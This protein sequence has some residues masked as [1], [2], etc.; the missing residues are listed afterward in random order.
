[1]KLKFILGIGA[2]IVMGMSSLNS[3]WAADKEK[4]NILFITVD[5]QRPQLNCYGK[6]G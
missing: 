1:M 3:I 4:L 2:A 5:N 6:Q